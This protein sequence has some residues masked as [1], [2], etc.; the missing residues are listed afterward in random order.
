MPKR[1]YETMP[2]S[3]EL[4]LPG[5]IKG[6]IGDLNDLR[7]GKITVQDAIARSL[8]AKQVFNGVRIYINGSNLLVD[9]ARRVSGP[10]TSDPE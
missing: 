8:L 3:D 2:V 7:A 5:V 10:D 4:G 9:N 6:L 1:D